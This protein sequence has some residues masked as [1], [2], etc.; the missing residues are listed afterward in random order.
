[1]D[2]YTQ[3]LGTGEP[4]VILHGFMG[5]S[6]NWYGI[7]KKI[8][9]NNTV[10]VVDLRNHG[11]S[12]HS[13]E[14]DYNVMAEDVHEVIQKH[15]IDNP[16]LMGH[17]MGGKVLM[18]YSRLFPDQFKKLI[19]VDIAPKAYPVHH[20]KILDGLLSINLNTLKS[21]TEA[22]KILSLYVPEP[23]IRMFL[24]KNL[25]RDGQGF[26]WK[27]NLPVLNK[28]IKEVGKETFQENTSQKPVIFIRG[29]NSPYIKSED[30]PQ[31]KKMYPH[32]SIVSIKDSG[33][34]LHA[35]QPEAFLKVAGHIISS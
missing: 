2:L 22:D 27:A 15:N 35:E 11:R 24:L 8:A 30:R 6:D 19:I 28:N 29:A 16:I 14:F 12:P 10:Y 5:T 7:A 26:T 17:S 23:S 31:I 1:M 18:H 25:D 34:W 21:R 13:D 33:H 32:A 20:Q 9:E 4:V 3:K